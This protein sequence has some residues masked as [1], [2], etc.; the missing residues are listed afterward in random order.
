MEILK[1]V[2][3][4]LHEILDI[5]DR[6]I[7]G[8]TYV[9]REMGAESIDL[10]EL[11]V[12]LNSRF[13]VDINDDEIFLRMLRLHMREATQEGM[14]PVKFLASR[15]PFL[16]QNRIREIVSDISRGPVLKMKDLA[17]YVA[18]QCER[19]KHP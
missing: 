1:E 5:D 18:W 7:T 2:A 8:E 13:C 11:S 12:A 10:L 17:A 4:M 3:A 16:T 9:I 15:Y 14:E 19:M 6:S